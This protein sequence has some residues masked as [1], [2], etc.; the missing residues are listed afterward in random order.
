MIFQAYETFAEYNQTDLA[1]LFT[2]PATVV[3]YFIPMVLFA[4]F[5]IIFLATSYSSRRL[6]I[7][8]YY[9]HSFAVAGYVTFVIAVVM[10]L[11]DLVNLYTLVIV[12]IVAFL[13]TVFLMFGK[14][15]V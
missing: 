5:M 10:T 1:G 3:E 9:T 14:R 12:S 15:D 11:L 7:K 4:I 2:Y 8:P 13:G 6:M